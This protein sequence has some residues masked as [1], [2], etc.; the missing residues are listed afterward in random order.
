MQAMGKSN[1]T[2]GERFA[3]FYIH[4]P[5]HGECMSVMTFYGETIRQKK[6]DGTPL[7]K[8][9]TDAGIIQGFKGIFSIYNSIV[10]LPSANSHLSPD[11]I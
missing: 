2:C 4:P 8:A 5:S 9:I 7:I 11:I 3:K 6:K 1:P 10:M